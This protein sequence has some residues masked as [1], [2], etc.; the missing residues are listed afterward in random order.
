MPYRPIIVT[1]NAAHCHKCGDIIESLYR[2]D[3]V[4]CSCGQ[5][6]VDGGLAYLRRV[7]NGDNWTDLGESHEGPE[8][9]YAW[10]DEEDTGLDGIEND[11][12]DQ[13]L[14]KQGY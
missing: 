13:V 10:E 8:R 1:R 3:F 2:H 11:G 5:V 14:K 6:S 9:N 12:Y 4:T 7:Y